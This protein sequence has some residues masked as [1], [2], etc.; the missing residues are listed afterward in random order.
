MEAERAQQ[1]DLLGPGEWFFSGVPEFV[2]VIQRCPECRQG[3]SNMKH[4]IQKDGSISPSLVC[5]YK[6]RGCTF[7]VYG[8]YDG[9]DPEIGARRQ[10][11]T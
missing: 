4:E 8:R 1:F 3:M 10:R 11:T 2:I 7:H 9:W 6:D 5:P